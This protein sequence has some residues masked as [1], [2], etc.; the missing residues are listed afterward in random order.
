M[1]GNVVTSKDVSESLQRL[2]IYHTSQFDST[3]YRNHHWNVHAPNVLLSRHRCQYDTSAPFPCQQQY[4]KTENPIMN[5]YIT[6]WLTI[7]LIYSDSTCISRIRNTISASREATLDVLKEKNHV[8][9]L[10]RMT[11]KQPTTESHAYSMGYIVGLDMQNELGRYGRWTLMPISQIPLC[12]GQMFPNAPLCNR[13]V[14]ACAHLCYQV[15][16]RV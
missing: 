4:N 6:P 2:Q 3:P 5:N 13:N 7:E 8:N 14:H 9:L 1:C 15:H 11:M 16:C 12:T 10:K